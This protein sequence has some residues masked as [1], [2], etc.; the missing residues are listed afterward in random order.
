LPP[1]R[2]GTRQAAGTWRGISA[3]TWTLILGELACFL[4]YGL[5][6]RDPRLIILGSTGVT[7]SMLMLIRVLWTARLRHPA[8]VA[9]LD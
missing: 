8:P 5:H 9:D 3:G 1:G 7:A 4:A 2:S 6:Q